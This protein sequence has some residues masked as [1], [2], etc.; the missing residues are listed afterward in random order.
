MRCIL[1]A[2]LL[3]ALIVGATLGACATQSQMITDS[4]GIPASNAQGPPLESAAAPTAA[5]APAPAPQP[6]GRAARAPT[7]PAPTPQPDG[8]M[9][10]TRAREQCWMLA[11]SQRARDID[12]RVKFVEQCVKD[13]MK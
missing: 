10:V 13:K 12:T 3:V 6:A 4:P 5:P 9:T 1:P 8:P 2:H 7:V 11:E